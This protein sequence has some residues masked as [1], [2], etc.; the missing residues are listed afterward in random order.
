MTIQQLRMVRKLV[1]C[2]SISKAAQQCFLSQSA[3][4]RQIQVMEKETGFPLFDRSFNGIKPTAPGQILY[5]EAG[6]IL[7]HY[8]KALR[9]ARKAYAASSPA[10]IRIGSYYYMT[11][12]IAPACQYCHGQDEKTDFDF[13]SC[14]LCDTL[15]YLE[16]QT[17]DMG[18]Y[19]GEPE[20]LPLSFYALPFARTYNI[21]KIP[22]GHPLFGKKEIF[23]RDLDCQTILL[24][25]KR[26][27]N[28]CAVEECI[29]TQGLDIGVDLYDSPDQAGNVSLAK[30]RVVLIVFPFIKNDHFW[31]API[32]DLPKPP[33]SLVTRRE[34]KEKYEEVLRRM[35]GYFQGVLPGFSELLPV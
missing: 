7:D 26:L 20:T 35:M 30:N 1:E 16:N 3:L 31:H 23:L 11:N 22:K 4:T 9:L 5:E 25:G 15:E 29:Q 10:G 27:D 28:I 18:I 24:S 33:M 13:V 21:C 8:E 32:R 17:I 2:G 34:D 19:V 12:F 14:R 6:P